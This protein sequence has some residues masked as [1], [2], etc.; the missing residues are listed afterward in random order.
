MDSFTLNRIEFDA[1]RRILGEFCSS[2]LG[3]NL[4]LRIEPGRNPE[5]ITR[6][7]EQTTQMVRAVRDTG[8]PPFGGVTNITDAMNR[9][10][11]GGGATGE[12]FAAIAFTLEGAKNLRAYLLGMP[13]ELNLL[14]ELGGQIG[15]F[16]AEHSAIRAI[17]DA[18]GSVR[19]DA[20]PRLTSLRE[21]IQNIGPKINELIY[22]YL[23]NT[24]VAKLLQNV[25]VTLHGDRYVL[26]VK[27]E[28]RG[29]LPGVVHR[30]S[31]TGAT[32]FIEPNACVEL[33]NKL[34][35][36]MEDERHEVQR[37]LNNL[38][39]KI[40]TRHAP[41]LAT[42]EV[43]SQVDLL[44]AKA[45]YSYQFE[46]TCPEIVERGALQFSQARHPLLINQAW[47]QEKAGIA[48]EKRH[49]VVPIDVRLGAD[50]DL[51]V[52]TG[53][54]T[55]GKTVTLKTVALLAVMAQSGMHL[56]VQ[57][58]ATMPVFRDIFIDIGDEQSLEQSLSTFGA[59]VKRL[60]HILA[61]ADRDCLVLLDELGSGTDPEEGGAIG[62]AILDELRRMG[63][64][65]MVTTH[66]SV[67]K[68]YAYNHDRVDNGSVEFDTATMSPTYH[69]RI[70]TPGESH[71]IA[72]AQRLGLPKRVVGAARQHFAGQG[73][74]FRKAIQSTNIARQTAEDARTQAQAAQVAAQTQ[75]EMY[76][77]KLADVRKLQEEF[78]TWLSQLSEFRPG[79]Q[80]FVPALNRHG[81]LVR[82]ELHRQIALVES[83][84][85]VQVEVPFRDIM[86][87]FGQRAVREQ[88]ARLKQQIVDQAK[89][90]EEANAKAQRLQSEFQKGLQQHREQAKQFDMWLGAIA[91]LKVGDVVP[92]N[93]NPGVGKIIKAD[94]PGLRVTV[95]TED[96]THDIS[97]QDVFP[98][99]GPFAQISRQHELNRQRQQRPPRQGAGERQPA[100]A[101][102]PQGRQAQ[103]PAAGQKPQAS[104]GKT[105][106]Y[107]A[108]GPYEDAGE[109]LSADR[110][111]NRRLASPREIAANREALLKVKP[112]EQVYVVP[113]HKQ[114]TLVRLKADRGLAVVASGA[115][116]ME[117][118]MDDVEP[119][120][121]PQGPKKPPKP[122][123]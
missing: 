74:Q 98:Q 80:M 96:G 101:A 41:I 104:Q 30:A 105:K 77:A 59:H 62:Q 108:P 7:L 89:T 122:H 78:E 60:R 48:P 121:A 115:M 93:R 25:A 10:K 21:E 85:G 40:Q 72:V 11:P 110:P 42:L 29:R 102:P 120:R 46:M 67:L 103:S 26:P 31:N 61:N 84:T 34:A 57:R 12:D 45:Q 73:K 58:G 52:I 8:L 37:L 95:H 22:H 32:V 6:S 118:S 38:A 90:T 65:G 123:P 100:Q 5:I 24:E 109:E 79:D 9:A 50:F 88:I 51:L 18:D 19:D 28:N 71:A 99:T 53:S 20:S 70:G 117:V 44:S 54:N 39:A 4:A 113:F 75:A 56:P 33:N 116:E 86:P 23:H 49:K 119:I 36:L 106:P 66:L 92:I 91:R 43:M 14:H 82:L 97:I 107:T 69:L 111:M 15:E 68:A 112:G 87:D 16:D 55:G 76:E 63:C 17:I 3:K 13:E 27:V 83:E 35:D 47:Q 2:A 94:L 114:A 1:V 64:L 81:K